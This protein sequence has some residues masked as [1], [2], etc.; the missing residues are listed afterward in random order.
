ML[1]PHLDRATSS[2]DRSIRSQ[3]ALH[4]LMHDSSSSEPEMART[5]RRSIGEALKFNPSMALH[6]LHTAFRDDFHD[7]S[8]LHSM[9][10]VLTIARDKRAENLKRAA[11][12][13]E[14]A[15]QLSPSPFS[16]AL[17]EQTARL[18]REYRNLAAVHSLRGDLRQVARYRALQEEPVPAPALRP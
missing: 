6:N 14:S 18:A 8:F 12:A 2:P 7:L 11:A 17:R 4:L 15:A 9:R 13:A 16:P 3:I 1:H 10:D 5:V